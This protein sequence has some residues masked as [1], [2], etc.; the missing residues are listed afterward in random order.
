MID[1][2]I[3]FWFYIG[4]HNLVCYCSCFCH[5][6]ITPLK[7]QIKYVIISAFLNS[8][9]KAI[10]DQVSLRSRSIAPEGMF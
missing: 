9:Y 6:Y 7:K 3:V 8:H 10:Y 1:K 2:N 4:F 5:G